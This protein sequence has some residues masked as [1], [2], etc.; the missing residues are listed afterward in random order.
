MAYR[1]QHPLPDIKARKAHLFRSFSLYYLV[2]SGS[3]DTLPESWGCLWLT[4]QAHIPSR[5]L[6]PHRFS[7]TSQVLLLGS[8]SS[9]PT[10][11]A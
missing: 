4:L 6:N 11:Y 8:L 1:G 9:C 10:P 5:Q 2:S 7:V 3:H